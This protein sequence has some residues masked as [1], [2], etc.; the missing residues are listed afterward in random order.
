MSP[1]RPSAGPHHW[2]GLAAGHSRNA[3]AD[4]LL[5]GLVDELPLSNAALGQTHR[6]APGRLGLSLGLPSA[7]LAEAAFGLLPEV[8]PRLAVAGPEGV[9][10]PERWH[11]DA[12]AALAAA[13]EGG[14]AVLFPGAA[15][16]PERITVAELLA[17]TAID[18]VRVLGGAA[19]GPEAWVETRGHLRPERLGATLTLRLAPARAGFVP[20][21]VP[22]PHPCCGGH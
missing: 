1:Q 17:R 10:G 22:D 8:A 14:R 7:S 2:L 13:P 15:G 11:A 16:L 6:V 20:F 3:D 19:V 18:A 12:V 9:R 21:E 5:L 4:H